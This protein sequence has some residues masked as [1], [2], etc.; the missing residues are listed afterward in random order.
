MQQAPRTAETTTRAKTLSALIGQRR[1]SAQLVRWPDYNGAIHHR[2]RGARTRPFE[3]VMQH[4]CRN[5][6]TVREIR[7]DHE[8]CTQFPGWVGV[9]RGKAKYIGG[10]AVGGRGVLGAHRVCSFLNHSPRVIYS[11]LHN[12]M[13]SPLSSFNITT[14]Q[15]QT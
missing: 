4:R 10:G 14:D 2:R 3:I 12:D 15:K 13:L 8:I 1:P 11:Y 6:A 9:G 5:R 7:D